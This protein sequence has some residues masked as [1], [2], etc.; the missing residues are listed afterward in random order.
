[1]P[2]KYMPAIPYTKKSRTSKAPTF[3]R[4]GAERIR[5]LNTNWNPF[6]TLISLKSLTI[7]K[8]RRTVALLIPIFPNKVKTDTKVT[9]QSNRFQE[10]EKY[11]FSPSPI[12]FISISIMNIATNT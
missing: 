2:N 7:R 12:I 4:A 1:M 11:D 10:V 6:K 8:A 5:V 3:I 9:T